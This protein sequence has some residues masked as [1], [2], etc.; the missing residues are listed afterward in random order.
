M[1]GNSSVEHE[2]VKLSDKDESEEIILKS[3]SLLN[4]KDQ[5]VVSR[6]CQ[7]ITD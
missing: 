1:C 3:L 7:S 4:V 6:M 5:D 2:E